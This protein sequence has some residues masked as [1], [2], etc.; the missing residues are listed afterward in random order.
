MHQLISQV[1]LYCIYV[2]FHYIRFVLSLFRE[3]HSTVITIPFA[4]YILKRQLF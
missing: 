3:M 4:V 1:T 2:I